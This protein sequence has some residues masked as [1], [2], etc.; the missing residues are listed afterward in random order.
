MCVHVCDLYLRVIRY[1]SSSV[2]NKCGAI[3]K[4]GNLVIK[5]P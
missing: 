2:M 5:L 1:L 3:I 4:L